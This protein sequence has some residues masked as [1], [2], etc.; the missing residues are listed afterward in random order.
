MAQFDHFTYGLLT[1]VLS[2][3]AVGARL[4]ARSDLRRRVPAACHDPARRAR[5]L[6][7][8]A[9]AIG[10]T[11]IWVMHFMAMLGFSVAGVPIRYDVPITAAS[12]DHRDRRGRRSACSSSGFGRPNAFKIIIGGIFTGLGVAAMHYTGMAAMRM[13][14]D[15]TYD[16]TLVDRLDRDRGGRRHGRAVVHRHAAARLALVGRRADHGRRGQRHALHRHVRDE[17]L[18]CRRR[19][20]RRHPAQRLPRPHRGV[21]GR[22]HR[23]AAGQPAQPVRGR[24]RPRRAGRPRRPVRAGARTAARRPQPHPYGRVGVRQPAAR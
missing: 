7:L 12:C 4:A 22:G 14:A 5:W 21:R 8:A 23:R 6:L 10:G 15:V 2:L 18:R 1:P 17:G 3:R 24:R 9:W 20:D 19:A 16:R 13:P 11:G